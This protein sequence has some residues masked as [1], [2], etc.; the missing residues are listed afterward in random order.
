MA[1][2]GRLVIDPQQGI[3]R[4]LDFKQSL[5]T[6]TVH[7]KQTILLS[8]NF[9]LLTAEETQEVQ[10]GWQRAQQ[11]AEQKLAERKAKNAQSG[12]TSRKGGDSKKHE[13]LVAEL[14][15]A[16][17]SQVL[18]ALIRVRQMS[19]DEVDDDLANAIHELTEH[20]SPNV[21]RLAADLSARLK[22]RSEK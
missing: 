4:R 9:R 13:K 7:E 18:G 2:Q 17:N 22:K 16:N 10:R 20:K 21:R 12:G 15:S 19:G 6:R 3:T 14:K 11:E 1:G 8:I 5:T